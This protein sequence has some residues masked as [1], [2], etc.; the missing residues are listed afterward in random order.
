MRKPGNK[1]AR[2]KTPIV[3]VVVIVVLGFRG[4]MIYKK[5]RKRGIQE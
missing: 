3:I 5:T 1:E 2:S 4:K